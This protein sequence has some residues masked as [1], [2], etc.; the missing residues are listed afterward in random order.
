MVLD[1][2]SHYSW[3]FPLR[4]KSDTTDTITRFFAYVQTQFHVTFHVTIQCMQCDKGGEFLTT[5][6]RSLF[7][8][9][10]ASFRMSCPH[11]SPQNGKAERLIRTTNDI[12][13]VLLT[14]ARLPKQFW[15]EALHTATHVLNRRPS[16]AI[17]H[18]T[19]HFRLLG[20]HPSY[21][22]LRVFGC[23]CFP[24]TY[25]TSPHKLA[26]RAVRY[27]F[28]G[29]ALEHKGYRCLDLASRRVIISR[30]VV[31]DETVFPYFSEIGR[32]HV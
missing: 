26:P 6:L 1:D 16:S 19:P 18:Q 17:A 20:R 12:L 21:D 14:H 23:L 7:S 13:R 28:L 27:V 15:V 22:H 31:F 9:H 5:P 3:T 25:A 30:H 32:A 10:G 8:R 2:F 11:T 24:N 4:N 29:Y